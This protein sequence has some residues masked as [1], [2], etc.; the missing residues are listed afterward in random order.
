MGIAVER[1]ALK[2]LLCTSK[3]WVFEK[4]QI[5][6]YKWHLGQVEHWNGQIIVLLVK[7]KQRKPDVGWTAVFKKHS[8]SSHE[9]ARGIEPASYNNEQSNPK[10]YTRYT[11][12]ITRCTKLNL[13]HTRL[14]KHCPVM[15]RP[16]KRNHRSYTSHTVSNTFPLALIYKWPQFAHAS[17]PSDCDHQCRPFPGGLTN[18][19]LLSSISLSLVQSLDH[20][21]PKWSL[22]LVWRCQY[23]GQ[24][25]SQLT[26]CQSAPPSHHPSVPSMALPYVRPS[27]LQLQV[28]Q[29]ICHT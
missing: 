27:C 18:I 13:K 20:R 4:K 16:R 3:H 15:E 7:T 1:V 23:I 8:L 10:W 6:T 12:L 29:L 28:T 19:L 11:R 26:T 5:T 9:R 2:K 14:G 25:R 21:T 24:R 17:F 22:F